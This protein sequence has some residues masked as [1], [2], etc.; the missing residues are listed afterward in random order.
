LVILGKFYRTVNQISKL[1]A[2]MS[3]L[4]I[5]K[6]AVEYGENIR[7]F[8]DISENYDIR[9]NGNGIFNYKISSSHPTWIE[10][11]IPE[12]INLSGENIEARN[13]INV[14]IADGLLSVNTAS[15]I[16]TISDFVK[17]KGWNV[18]EIPDRFS[19]HPSNL[20]NLTIT[21]IK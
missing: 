5:S 18:E 11:Q 2:K 10:V 15:L 9:V 19:D 16:T 4:R 20:N 6:E 8:S 7:L 21:T 13:L 3:T 12:K 17:T 1:R 14:Q